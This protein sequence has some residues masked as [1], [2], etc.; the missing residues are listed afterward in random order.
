MVNLVHQ[1]YI[2]QMI[3]PADHLRDAERLERQ[4]E[5]AESQHA[6]A[7]LRRM[8]QTSRMTA[9]FVA[10]LDASDAEHDRPQASPVA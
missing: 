1:P 9:A 7:A 4:A 3:D 2:F 6:R 5:I 8:A 10:M